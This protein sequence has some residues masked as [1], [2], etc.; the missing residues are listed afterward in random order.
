MTP[1]TLR[2][3]KTHFLCV[4]D[5]ME[6]LVWGVVTPT[7]LPLHHRHFCR[8]SLTLCS[9]LWCFNAFLFDFY[10]FECVCHFV[11]WNNS[12]IFFGSPPPPTPSQ[13]RNFKFRAPC[14]I[15]KMARI[16]YFFPIWLENGPLFSVFRLGPPPRS[17]GPC[18]PRVTLLPPLLPSPPQ[19]KLGGPITI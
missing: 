18:G 14:R 7:T 5:H 1:N 11:D 12:A 13:W 17:C 10:S 16:P 8:L 2:H 15:S 3:T 19:L 9:D 6:H 4:S